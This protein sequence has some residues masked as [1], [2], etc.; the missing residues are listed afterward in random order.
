[1]SG[2]FHSF[3]EYFFARSCSFLRRARNFWLLYRLLST[4]S[5]LVAEA[6]RLGLIL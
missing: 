5:M 1:M 2:F 6:I 4:S 3:S